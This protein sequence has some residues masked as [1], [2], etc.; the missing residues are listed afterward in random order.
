M[1]ASL[2][3]GAANTHGIEGRKESAEKAK[4]IL[5]GFDQNSWSMETGDVYE[6][7]PQLVKKNR[8]FDTVLCLGLFYHVYDHWKLLQLMASVQP[9]VIVIDSLFLNNLLPVSIVHFDIVDDPSNAIASVKNQR[10]SPVGDP[11]IGLMNA[12][13]A[14]LGYHCHWPTYDDLGDT[15]GLEDYAQKLRHTAVLSKQDNPAC[16][17]PAGTVLEHSVLGIKRH[18]LAL[19][20][21]LGGINAGKGVFSKAGGNTRHAISQLNK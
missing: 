11:S 1:W 16:P 14:I 9:D 12:M 6:S 10:F 19:T 21:L 8:V 15:T 5:G 4:T 20:D 2:N 3:A 18:E 7:I 13:A 17:A